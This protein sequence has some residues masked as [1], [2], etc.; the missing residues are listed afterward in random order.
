MLDIDYAPPADSEIKPHLTHGPF[1]GGVGLALLCELV[2]MSVVKTVIS[3]EL[4]QI[5]L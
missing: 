5:L 3:F 1:G 2:F 4:I